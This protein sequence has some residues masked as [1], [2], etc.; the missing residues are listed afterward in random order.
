LS[1]DVKLFNS[2]KIK[3][4]RVSL[5]QYF[6]IKLNG[7]FGPF[8]RP[9]KWVFIVGCYNSGTTLLHKLL[10]AHP[11]IG[12]MANEGQFYTDQLVL[13]R[14]VG[15][16]RLWAIK[17]EQFYLDENSQTDI[18]V[19]SLKRQWGAQFNDPTRLVLLEKSPTN[20]ARTR[21]LQKQFEN[22]HFIGIVRNGYAVAEGIHR[23]GHHPLDVAAKQWACSNEI[24]L[25]DFELLNNQLLIRYEDLVT[26]PNQTFQKMLA[27]LGLSKY[28]LENIVEHNWSIHK[29]VSPIIDMNHRSLTALSKSERDIIRLT[30]GDMLSRLG[31]DPQLEV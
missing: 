8:P 26:S 24:M 10:A 23:K 13:P 12:S 1:N 19:N 29:E 27:F 21:W 14:S 31:Y 3:V 15:L 5:R 4:N 6:R 9:D 30:A 22:A 2:L 25:R 17:P 20:A 11:D 16:Y 7:I 18:N 28:G